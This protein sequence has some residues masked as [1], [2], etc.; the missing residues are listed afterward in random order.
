[1]WM[2]P[3]VNT[4]HSPIVKLKYPCFVFASPEKVSH[5]KED[6]PEKIDYHGVSK[7]YQFLITLLHQIDVNLN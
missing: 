1:M 5:T 4:D 6:T 2:P 7:F 3:P